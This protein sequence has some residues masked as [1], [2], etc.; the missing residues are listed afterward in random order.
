MRPLA[1]A[2]IWFGCLSLGQLRGEDHGTGVG[3]NAVIAAADSSS[4]T[5]AATSRSGSLARDQ[6]FSL[7]PLNG[8]ENHPLM[9]ALRR[10]YDA[11]EQMREI[12]DYTC[13]LIKR[14]RVDGELLPA[15]YIDLKL[16]HHPFGV[17][18]YFRAPTD[19]RGREVLFVP[20]ENRGRI[21]AQ[22]PNIG[23]VTLDPQSRRALEDNRYPISEI[24]ILTLTRRLV[25]VGLSE[26]DYGECKVTMYENSKINGRNCTCM[27]FEHPVPR[28][29][30]RYHLARVFI[31]NELNI[32]IRYEAY[33]WPKEP[34]GKPVL[35][36]EYTYLDVKLNVG[37]TD[38]DF[39]ADNTEYGFGQRPQDV[40]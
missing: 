28:R 38:R 17:H 19:K 18:L 7:P 9:P 34:G 23:T 21:V 29:E 6:I 4:A 27:Q 13:T 36:E 12:R 32:P 11:V 10:A 3:S 31:D 33:T 16:R 40:E 37:L 39:S 5:P 15:E 14:E 24:G 35:V 1:W 25:E 30:F 20:S 2:L 8:P 26:L 22:V